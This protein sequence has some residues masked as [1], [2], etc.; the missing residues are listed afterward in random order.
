MTAVWHKNLWEKNSSK[1]EL[2]ES[3]AEVGTKK[4]L[5]EISKRN[6]TR[7]ICKQKGSGY[8]VVKRVHPLSYSSDAN[9]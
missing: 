5:N 7:Q 8:S 2:K 6:F 4:N 9:G 1:K 3:P